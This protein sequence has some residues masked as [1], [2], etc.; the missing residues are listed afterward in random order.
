MN[1]Q[2]TAWLYT[3]NEESVR[4]ELVATG[5]GVQLTIDGPGAAR[6]T[7]DFPAGTAVERFREEYEQKLMADG[8]KL[9]AVAERRG[10]PDRGP[11][12]TDR[13]RDERRARR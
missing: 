12:S 9:Q 10:N 13:R 7:Y 4:L 6:A 3:R 5:T 1:M 2:R 11:A 8:Y